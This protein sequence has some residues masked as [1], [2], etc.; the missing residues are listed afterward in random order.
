MEIDSEEYMLLRK[1][2][3]DFIGWQ[4]RNELLKEKLTIPYEIAEW[5]LEELLNETT[6]QP[7]EAN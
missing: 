5:Y 3:R 6:S 2:L 7:K 1:E 4:L